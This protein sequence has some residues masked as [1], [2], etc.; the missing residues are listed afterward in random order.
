MRLPCRTE[1]STFGHCALARR[2]CVA[3]R[4][5]RR[6]PHAL[7]LHASLF[8]HARRQGSNYSPPSRHSFSQSMRTAILLRSF[9]S[10]ICAASNAIPH[11]AQRLVATPLNPRVSRLRRLNSRGNGTRQALLVGGHRG[12]RLGC[13]TMLSHSIHMHGER[14]VV[15]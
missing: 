4:W 3:W 8:A 6:F 11:I 10:T 1:I 7:P 9:S 15:T 2:T 5:R 14:R 13:R 12:V